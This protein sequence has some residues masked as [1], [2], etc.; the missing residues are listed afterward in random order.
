MYI[1]F[2]KSEQKLGAV[3]ELSNGHTT[4]SLASSIIKK[5]HIIYLMNKVFTTFTDKNNVIDFIS[6]RLEIIDIQIKAYYFN[7][8]RH[9]TYKSGN[10]PSISFKLN[11]K[12]ANND[13]LAIIE[14]N[15]I[16]M[17]IL[18]ETRDIIDMPPDIMY[19]QSLLEYI[20]DFSKKHSLKVLEKYDEHRLK[21]EGLDGILNVGRGSHNKPRMVI[22]E[23]NGTGNVDIAPVVLVGKGVTYDSGG[24]SIKKTHM[25][26]MK[27]D[28]TG[29]VII[30][31]VMGVIAKLK[32]KCRV[33]AILPMAENVI[34]PDSFKPDEV[35]K[36]HSGL[37]VEVFNT[38]AEGRLILMDGISM[39]YKYN[40]KAIID[41][42]TLTAMGVFCNKLGGIFGNNQELSWILQRI[43]EKHG[44]GFWVMPPLD[45]FV[46]DTKNTDIAN[47][48]N[49][50]YSCSSGSMMGAAFLQN[51]VNPKIPWIHMDIG[52]S[53][54]L[55]EKYDSQDSAK[56]NSFLTLVYFLKAVSHT[57]VKA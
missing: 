34:G 32:L 19:P 10:K 41:V 12:G 33:I 47:V 21:L 37:S 16:I 6:D 14:E 54:S 57:F 9:L 1:H 5:A 36:S 50:G 17:D 7:S 53:K 42:A 30:T 13:V 55:Y 40:P 28:K 8:Y 26:N 39:A 25:K 23:Y 45:D 27:Q 31:G 51:F 44:D 15:K 11:T 52:E 24:Y 49:E 35:I 56:S 22:L 2:K 29:V 43:G 4:I 3:L 20:V 18:N 46:D 48:K 38:D